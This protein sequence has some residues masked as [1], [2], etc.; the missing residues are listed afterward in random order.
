MKKL[1]WSLL[2][3][4]GAGALLPGCLK[5]NSAALPAIDCAAE[6]AAAPAAETTTLKKQLDSLRIG[7][8]TED[9][10]GFYYTIDSVS[11]PSATEAY[12]TPCSN[13]AVTYTITKLGDTTAVFE[14]SDSVVAIS[15]PYNNVAGLKAAIPLMKKGATMKL[16]LPPSLAYGASGYKSI[17][18]NT[19]VMFTIKLYDF[20]N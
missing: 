9:T 12:A 18:G 20:T 11:I 16:Y 14:K 17:P 13:V 1:M 3:I 19:Y 8:V 4:A 5:D 6:T 7:M 15:L 10:H 2:C